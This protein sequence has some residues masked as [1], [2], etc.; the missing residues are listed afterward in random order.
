MV[1]ASEAKLLPQVSHLVHEALLLKV[2]KRFI[3]E[4]PKH[5]KCTTQFISYCTKKST[6]MLT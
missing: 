1:Y 2:L 4:T 3:S 5:K 6:T